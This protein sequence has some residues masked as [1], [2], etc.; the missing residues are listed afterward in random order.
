LVDSD[1]VSSPEVVKLLDD[2]DRQVV[3]Y[4]LIVATPSVCSGVNITAEHFD[5]VLGYGVGG[6]HATAEEF[7]QGVNRVRHPKDPARRLYLDPRE[8]STSPG[9]RFCRQADVEI[10]P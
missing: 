4:D 3:N 5:A 1:T 7:L 6:K 10:A 9:S 2:P 8:F